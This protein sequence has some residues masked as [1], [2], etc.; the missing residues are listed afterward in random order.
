MKKTSLREG[1]ITFSEGQSEFF[2]KGVF[3]TEI[4]KIIFNIC[5]AL[6]INSCDVAKCERYFNTNHNNFVTLL[7][8]YYVFLTSIVALL[9]CDTCNDIFQNNFQSL[10]LSRKKEKLNVKQTQN[11]Q[12]CIKEPVQKQPFA[13]ALQNRCS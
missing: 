6:H 2:V 13:D 12:R 11:F 5:K 1:A 10:F 3:A 7:C 4:E 8:S 9:V